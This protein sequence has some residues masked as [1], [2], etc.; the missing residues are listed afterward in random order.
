MP[1]I[2]L[3]LQDALYVIVIL[4]FLLGSWVYAKSDKNKLIFI[5]WVILTLTLIVES[6]G[7]VVIMLYNKKI[8]LEPN[9]LGLFNLYDLIVFFLWFYLFYQI[10]TLKSK[11]VIPIFAFLILL[12]FTLE[13]IF[14]HNL[15]WNA[16]SSPIILGSLFL[17]VTVFLYFSQILQDGSVL[18]LK[19]NLFFWTS[20]GLLIYYVVTIPFNVVRYY[21]I[22]DSA[23]YIFLNINMST[24]IIMYIFMGIG[25]IQY[26][27]NHGNKIEQ[28]YS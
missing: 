20:C 3:F 22:S 15:L 27:K 28:G 7:F 1:S 11:K 23:Y 12:S 4:L 16:A 14:F 9:T 8:L 19:K 18:L 10:S 25:L 26:Y 24:A 2:Y 6:I 21:Y 17:A 13:W 5:I